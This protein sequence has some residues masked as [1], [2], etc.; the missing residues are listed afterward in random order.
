MTERTAVVMAIAAFLGGLH[1]ME[2]PL[3]MA[4]A[5]VTLVVLARQ[6]L[7]LP[8]VVLVLCSSLAQRSWDGLQ[9]AEPHP[10]QGTATVVTDPA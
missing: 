6:P 2:L 9:P 10:L 5:G 3:W 7:L 1:P 4:V 8:L